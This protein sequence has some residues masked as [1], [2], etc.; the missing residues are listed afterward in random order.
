M[1]YSDSMTPKELKAWRK[2]NDYSQS[3]LARALSVHTITISRWEISLREI[4]SFLRLALERLE[5]IKGGALN[6]KGKKTR[7]KR[8]VKK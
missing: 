5:E 4:P 2:R 6:E 3:Q 1:V 7:K 8:E